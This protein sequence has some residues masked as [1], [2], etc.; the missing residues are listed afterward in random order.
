MGVHQKGGKKLLCDGLAE[1]NRD[2]SDNCTALVCKARRGLRLPS[3]N[4]YRLYY[5]RDLASDHSDC[6]AEAQD[7]EQCGKY[8]IESFGMG[9]RDRIRVE[10]VAMG[11]EALLHF[12]PLQNLRERKSTRMNYSHS[13]ASRIPASV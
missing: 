11:I 5:R 9:Y 7:A 3:R 2:V 13:C 8:F 10:V 12:T 6:L 1:L 4:V